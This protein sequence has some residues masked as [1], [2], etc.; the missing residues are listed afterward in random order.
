MST[1]TVTYQLRHTDSAD[2]K[3]NARVQSIVQT[4]LQHP[5]V[6]NEKEIAKTIKE[7]MDK[8]NGFS[9]HCI[10]GKHFGSFVT[11]DSGTFFYIVIDDKLSILL[12]KN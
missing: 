12:Y 7:Q 10:V 5:N 6:N 4:A 1:S 2:E 9:W 11:H 8:E 3:L